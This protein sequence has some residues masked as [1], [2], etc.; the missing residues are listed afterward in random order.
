[1]K[2]RDILFIFDARD[3]IP[4]GERE[5]GAEGPR[6]D[7]FSNK[8]IISDVCLK[9]TI[10][11]YFLIKGDEVDNI[12]VRQKFE[13][14]DIGRISMKKT[15]IED[16]GIK[17][18]TLKEMDENKLYDA[19]KT[20]F[21]D[22]RL[23]GS[24]FYLNR[25]LTTTT[26]AVQFEN[27]LSYNEP[28][29]IEFAITSTIASE[30][31]KGAGAMGRSYIIDYAIFPVH[32]IAKESLS[33]ISGASELDI[34]K[35]FDA[36][37]NGIKSRITRTKFQQSPRLIISLVMKDHR[38]QIPKFKS[39][40]SLVNQN[41]SSFENCEFEIT[42]FVELVKNFNDQIEMIEFREDP[43]VKYRYKEDNLDSINKIVKYIPDCPRLVELKDY[44]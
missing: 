20:K 38:L 42:E 25:E 35:L 27:T 8:T 39:S 18:D 17:K 19:I 36:L 12:L 15:L 14:S 30:S 11:D 31:G 26:G 7:A 5:T 24:I 3:C 1:M 10:R 28:N 32:G 2:S 44:Y 21:I 37:W 43:F 40:I 4:N 9:R 23:F 33:K 41:V 16:I 13:Y 29:V 34:I 6:I 22:H